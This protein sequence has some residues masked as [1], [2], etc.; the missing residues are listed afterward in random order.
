MEKRPASARCMLAAGAAALLL[1]ACAPQAMGVPVHDAAPGSAD[2]RLMPRVGAASV[3]PPPAPSLSAELALPPC[4]TLDVAD[5]RVAVTGSRVTA[6]PGPPPPPPPPPS[7]PPPPRV[8]PPPP[9][10][11][12]VADS[13]AVAAGAPGVSNVSPRRV[14]VTE[15]R[16]RYDGEGVSAVRA[17]ADAPVSTFSVDVDTGSYANVR[18]M[19][20]DCELPPAAA[21]RT[22]E[23]L[24]YFR[25]DL[26]RP[27]DRAVPFS[28]TTSVAQSPW[29]E[30]ARLMRI[31]IRGYDIDRATR[32]AANLVFLV[33]VS[34]SM[35]TPDKLPLVKRSLA[36]LA[37]R[38]DPRDRIS[39]VTYAGAAGLALPATSSASAVKEVLSR[40]EAGGSTAG[41]EGLMLAYQV[42]RDNFITGGVNRVM[43][44]T[45]GDFNV[46]VSSDEGI[47][48]IVTRE[49][50]RGITLST[51][52]YGTG[53]YNEA[54]MERIA[55][56]GNG[57]YS[58]IDTIAEAG[59]V[60]ADEMAGTVFTIAR[61]VKIQVEFNPA[62]ISEYR[63][64]GY[65][66]RALRDEDFAN[67]AVDAGD[68]GSGHQVTA[69]YE[70]VPVGTA[71]W[72][73]DRRYAV[74]PPA[75]T[76]ADEAATVRLRYKLPDGAMSRLTE[77]RVPASAIRDAGRATGDMGFAAA[78]AA[79]GQKLRGDP[80]LAGLG[81]GEVAALAGAQTD[82]WRR[83]F[84]ALVSRAAELSTPAPAL[85]VGSMPGAEAAPCGAPS[86]AAYIGRQ[87]DRR[88]RDAIVR[89]RQ[90]RA[91]RF[92]APGDMVT[93]DFIEDRLNVE[94]D[95]QGRMVA[96]RCG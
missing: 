2:A 39:I 87:A 37:D 36:M 44:A 20:A 93:M 16:E 40:L 46:G 55:D 18:R 52:G 91:V 86:L 66:N 28:V 50:A 19:L 47:E 42:A 6:R 35:N 30:G 21:V 14:P 3:S 33:D 82:P 10:G 22:E 13:V 59:K 23:M 41:G 77:G 49:R 71:G 94:L 45:D 58:Y 51:L 96:M 62:V 24:N 25:Y 26:P 4:R 67:D 64:I 43:L 60:L 69:L 85:P 1:G 54:M 89:A 84:L 88:A 78:V 57:N 38:L 17:V 31:G 5:E 76:R 11:I 7:P 15:T 68:I 73:S 61:D 56:V 79:Y 72:L 63:L 65:E 29:K 83:Q 48:A 92:I 90:P 81:W 8:A 12:V 80:L 27:T 70:V 53:N 75:P 9:P 32:P 74:T 95:A 34:G